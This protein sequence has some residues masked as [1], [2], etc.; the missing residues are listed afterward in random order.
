MKNRMLI[1]LLPLL[2]WLLTACSDGFPDEEMHLGLENKI[3]PYAITLEPPEASPGETVQVTLHAHIP[4]GKTVDIRWQVALDYNT[5][6]YETDEIERQIL[7]VGQDAVITRD[8]PFLTQ[9]FTWTVPDSVLRVTSAI[10]EV[11]TDPVLAALS[12]LVIGPAAGTPP[13]RAGVEEWILTGGPGH[14]L[15]EDEEALVDRFSC[16]VRFRAVME[17]ADRTVDVTRNLTVRYSR[18]LQSS[19]VNRNNTTTGRSVVALEK[20]DASPEDLEDGSL[21]RHE[22]TL[23][24]S[25]VDNPVVMPFHADWTYF[26]VEA[27]DHQDYNAPFEPGLVVTEEMEGR[28]YYYRHD[29][30]TAADVFFRNDDGDDP[31]MWELDDDILLEPAGPATRYALMTVIR[32]TRRDWRQYHLSPGQSVYRTELRFVTP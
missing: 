14:P 26:L 24:G 18:S 2:P 31:E 30:P 12:Q 7:P 29:D 4:E 20:R 15:S 21:A 3:R 11:L 16:A 25:G 17:T 19:Q 6:L 32:D 23:Q 1:A 10:P 5:G 13:T 27:F 9:S 28:W 22:Y 8:G